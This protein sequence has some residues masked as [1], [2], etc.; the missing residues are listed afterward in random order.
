MTIKHSIEVIPFGR[1]TRLEYQRPR[2][3]RR[4]ATTFKHDFP[5]QGARMFTTHDGRYIIIEART[6]D[7]EIQ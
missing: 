4:A 1:V 7:G 6:A 5:R 2:K 3:G